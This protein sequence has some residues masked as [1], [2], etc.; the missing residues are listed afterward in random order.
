MGLQN[1]TVMS[2][3]KEVPK[4]TLF[5][6]TEKGN[7]YHANGITCWPSGGLILQPAEL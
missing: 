6:R 4:Q 7:K 1:N 5:W 3:K 2:N